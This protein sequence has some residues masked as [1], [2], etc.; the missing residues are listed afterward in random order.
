MGDWSKL[1]T[2]HSLTYKMTEPL[3]E[4]LDHFIDLL[5]RKVAPLIFVFD[6]TKTIDITFQIEALLAQDQKNFEIEVRPVVRFG[7]SYKIEKAKNH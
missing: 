6:A 1:L 4:Q 7:H 2:P 3:N 5:E